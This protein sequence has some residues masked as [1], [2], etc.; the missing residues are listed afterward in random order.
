[1]PGMDGEATYHALRAIQE[2]LPV[3]LTSGFAEEDR[4]NR[5]IEQ[6]AKGMVHKPYKSKELAARIREVLAESVWSE[7][8]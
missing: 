2:D 1:M 7:D 3:L 8:S 5:L 4:S 6:G